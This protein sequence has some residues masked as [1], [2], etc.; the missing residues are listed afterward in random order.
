[1]VQLGD[2][3][4]R[5]SGRHNDPD[6]SL[7]ALGDAVSFWIGAQRAAPVARWLERELDAEG[8]PR[9]LP[10]CDWPEGLRLLA[11]A[12]LAHPGSCPERS[13]A[14]L[15]GWFRALLRCSRPNGPPAFVMQ[16][17]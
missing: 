12:S 14:L 6:S 1:M 9:R 15:E 2:I 10:V 5:P 8:G 17:K 7:S 16:G 4:E 3:G 13:D 11:E